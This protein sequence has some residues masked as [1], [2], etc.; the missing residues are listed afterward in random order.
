M[1]SFRYIRLPEPVRLEQ[2]KT[3]VLLMSTQV[4]DGDHFRDPVSFDG[5]SPQLN[6][7]FVIQ[8]SLLLRES[9]LSGHIDVPAFEDLTDFYSQYRLPVGPTLRLAENELADEL[10]TSQP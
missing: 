9:S 5:L 3:Y 8:R 10:Q 6:R 4:A 1:N 7:D 2:G